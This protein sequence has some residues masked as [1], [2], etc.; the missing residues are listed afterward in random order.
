MAHAPR[1]SQD[2]PERSFESAPAA[3]AA[4]PAPVSEPVPAAQAVP[5]PR[6]HSEPRSPA[7]APA[8]QAR[9][10][11]IPDPEQLER[12]LKASGLELVQTRSKAEAAPEPEFVPAK[13]E[14]RPP[15]PDLSQPLVQVE[16]EQKP[17]APKQN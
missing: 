17:D 6:V 8:A 3:A 14:R 15:P 9:P 16:T 1:E 12:N 13:R 4:T 5:A 2:R 10:A 11:A 7:P